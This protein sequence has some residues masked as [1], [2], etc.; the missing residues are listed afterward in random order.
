M[1]ALKSYLLSLNDC[2]LL[3][4]EQELAL[5][6]RVAKWVELRNKPDPTPEERR[7]IRSGQRAREH[8]IRANLRLVVAVAKKYAK[9]RQT[10]DMLDLIQ[11]GNIGLATA[12]EKFD[13][14]RGYKFSTYAFW[15]IR[16]A[17]TKAIQQRDR[18]IRL[19]V[20]THDALIRAEPTRRRLAQALGRMPTLE[21][22]AA[23]MGIE[24]PAELRYAASMGQR[25]SS[26]DERLSGSDGDM[27][28]RLDSIPAPDP[29]A[30]VDTDE[31]DALADVL[32]DGIDGTARE[33]LLARYGDRQASWQEL[34]AELSI[35]A[36]RL[37]QLD[38]RTRRRM[39]RLIE[40]KLSGAE[41]AAVAPVRPVSVAADTEQASFLETLA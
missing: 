19:P 32:R 8:F 1:N 30:N 2:P 33:V 36:A 16:Q 22:L 38:Q 21:E 37:K 17:V 26:L 15:W 25:P 6:R 24:D 14:A 18:A 27:G 5:G 20:K 3:T 39:A 10:L 11:E 31:L 34:S 7:L 41:I 28:C 23:E 12:V 9:H 40:A 29:N 13:P 35:P 4:A